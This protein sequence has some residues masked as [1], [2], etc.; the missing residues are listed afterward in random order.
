MFETLPEA[1]LCKPFFSSNTF[2]IMS[3]AS[4]NTVHS[5]LITVQV[6]GKNQLE[7]AQESMGEAPVLLQYCLL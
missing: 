5:M 7:R 6:T 1:F 4:Q 3:V 2:L